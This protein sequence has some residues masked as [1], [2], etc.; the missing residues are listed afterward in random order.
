MELQRAAELHERAI[1]ENARGR[2]ALARRLL[3]QALRNDPD[4][5]RRAHILISLA[6][7]EAERRNLAAGLDLLRAAEA[8]P[9]LPR[10]LRGLAASQRGL[11]YMRAGQVDEAVE[12]FSAALRLL[13]GS[14]PHDV[15]RALLNRG[16]L[17]MQHGG[18]AA[19][20]ADFARCAGLARRNGLD[21]LG[22]KAAHNLGYLALLS[23]DLPRALREMDA[24]A[25]S[26][27][28]QSPV[29][30]AV[31]HIDRAQALL[32]AGLSR[33]ADEDL[34]RA[35]ELF[36]AARVRQDQA[37][38]E[39]ARAQV[40]MLEQRWADARALAARAR[41]RFT[42]RGAASWALLAAH[43]S[44]AARVEQGLRPGS[45]ATEAAGLAD[46]LQAAGLDEDARRARLTAALAALAG[47]H[48]GSDRARPDRGSDRAG[49]ERGSDRAG[50]ERGSD[51]VE[52]AAELAGTALL[53]RRD[54]P[55]GTRLSARLA[56]AAL[57]EARGATAAANRERRA[58]LADLHRYQASFGSHDL[59]TAASGHGRRLAA[60]GLGWALS[61]GRPAEVFQWA[62]RA[63]ALSARLAPVLPPADEEAAALLEQLRHARV[64]LRAQALA[65]RV[66][67]S[68]RARC[69]RLEQ[70]IRQRSWYA[71]GAGETT[72]PAPL[73]RLCG[74][75]GA[76]DATFVAHLLSGDRLHALVATGRRQT[77]RDLGPAA[78]AIETHRQLRHDLDALAVSGLPEQIRATVRS[79]SRAAVR[80][81]D[82]LLWEPVRPLLAGG[83]L[84]LAPSADLA[85][86]PWTMLPTL[87]GCPVAVVA[88]V[89]A[90]LDRR[91][92]GGLPASP[93]VA[94]AT[95]PGLARGADEIRLVAKTW[96]L[97]PP[98]EE[99]STADVR[100]AAR[101][102]DVLHIA[103]HGVHEPDNPLF[104]H[105]GLADGPLFGHDLQAL[106]RLPEHVVLSAC[107]LGLAST[108]PG[109]E[110]LGMTASFLH[111]GAG[112]VVAGV[113]RIADAAA[114]QVAPAHHAALSRGLSPAAALAAATAAVD[115]D[116][117]PVPLVCF[118]AGW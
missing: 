13:D 12:G 33:E 117:D 80:R 28:G 112:S 16:I 107:E 32:A 85:T 90:W 59:R 101:V 34:A 113:A 63:R 40:A 3:H 66:D 10:R 86:V 65:G 75:L 52:R 14:A 7:H 24:V 94:L 39:L 111:G 81:L 37:E 102:A 56:R 21:L 55:I 108:R 43:V 50:P 45:A 57:A 42:D 41:R 1:A 70:R 64:E 109:D 97:N 54:D 104:S 2:H 115:A 74:Q 46:Q 25:P 35:V 87:R 11:L 36:R 67:P 118:G 79:A 47:P 60:D 72:E 77:V 99:A 18:Y 9:R 68:L 17:A 114:Y 29:Y 78:A 48:R 15:C 83:P 6:Y 53:L 26:L 116:A 103:A 76:A 61:T 88:S 44:V 51:R 49:P 20:K 84:L 38:A 92:C 19:A 110:T 8:V 58:G 98:E 31:Y 23:G 62:E 71:S 105:L 4:P 82:A 96:S 91:D 89:T 100:H 106:G 95:G 22:A 93:R 5:Q 27:T 73:H 30:A 69:R